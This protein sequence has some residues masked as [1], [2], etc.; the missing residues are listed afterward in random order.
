MV[1][2][3]IYI[4]RILTY[5][6]LPIHKTSHLHPTGKGESARIY[7][8]SW[9][10]RKCVIRLFPLVLLSHFVFVSR[11]FSLLFQ[12][13][14]I[15]TE[16]FVHVTQLMSILHQ[17]YPPS[18]NV[19]L[20]LIL[21]TLG[22]YA[23]QS[24]R[25]PLGPSTL[26]VNISNIAQTPE[27]LIKPTNA[28]IVVETPQPSKNYFH[29]K[30]DLSKNT[31]ICHEND[32][33][34]LYILSTVMNFKRREVVRSTWASKQV[35]V[36]FVFILGQPSKD[37]A[38]TQLKA[39]NEKKQYQDIVQTEH[40]ESYENVIYKEVGA[41][42]WAKT[43]YPNI[44][45]L[46][47]T[48]DDLIVDSILVSSIAYLLANNKTNGDTLMQR[49]RPKMIN[50]LLAANRTRFFRGGWA[51]DYQPTVR[52]GGKYSVSEE[53]WPHPV[54]PAY[55]SGFGWFMSNDT[56]DR[57]VEA[58]FVYPSNKI[59][60][61]GDV[62]ASGFLAKTADVKCTGIEIDFEQTGSANCSCS[63]VT[64]PMLTVCSSTFHVDG[65]GEEL[66]KYIE[67]QKAWQVIQFRHNTT[68]TTITVC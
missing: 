53:V 25:I 26:T 36:C 18:L 22:I 3:L 64:H 21:I 56:R 2:S 33:L 41:L 11:A 19:L 24:G 44:P 32:H 34:I 58:S 23:L 59:V 55:C 54:L 12:N 61:V 35:G 8:G 40:V 14:F 67:Y 16:T 37:I 7:W 39:E 10:F 66:L 49:Y 60:W 52:G 57:L 50:E 9:E 65:G 46:F 20:G 4:L 38:E 63:M 1:E 68:N 15:I 27:P 48:D 43:F 28:P 30:L 45:Y 5:Y 31:A 29:A 47:K 51:M 42:L 62:F 13:N 6:Y 17:S